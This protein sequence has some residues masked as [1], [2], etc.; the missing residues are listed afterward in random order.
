MNYNF[1]D[2]NIFVRKHLSDGQTV[3][4][5]C[6]LGILDFSYKDQVQDLHDRIATHLSKNLFAPSDEEEI[7]KG[8]TFGEGLSVGVR[9]DDRVISVRNILVSKSWIAENMEYY[10][11]K[12]G[13]YGNPAITDFCV[14][15]K[16]FRGNNIQFLTEHYAEN[17]LSEDFDSLITTV[18]PKNIFSLQNVLACGFGIINVTVTYGGYARFILRKTFNSQLHLF[19]HG[20]LQI[21]IRDSESQKKALTNGYIGY[22]IVRKPH[23]GFNVL[24]AKAKFV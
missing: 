2:L 21:P 24:F 5:K 8:M 22:R 12:S 23:S 11:F 4:T 7:R 20:H 19:T 17:L 18:S 15:D 14:V 13:T 16:E 6:T 3:M 1:P 10:G 9:C